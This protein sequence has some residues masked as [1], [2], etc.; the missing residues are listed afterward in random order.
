MYCKGCDGYGKPW[1]TAITTNARTHMAN[2]HQVYVD[3][4]EPKG[5]KVRQVSLQTALQM[6]VKKQVEKNTEDVEEI[7][8]KALKD[9]FYE[10][11]IQ[12]ITRRRLP[13][14]CVEWPE[15]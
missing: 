4:E 7:L 15:Y 8:T 3:V 5:K 12:L 1:A 11:Q 2:L 9:A 6:S 10:A 14:N 13:F